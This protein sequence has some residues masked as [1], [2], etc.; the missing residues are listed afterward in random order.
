MLYAPYSVN[1]SLIR[2]PPNPAHGPWRRLQAQAVEADTRMT[3]SGACGLA[4][5]LTVLLP[6]LAWWRRRGR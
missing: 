4:F 1:Q 2:P 6:L 5:E 3:S